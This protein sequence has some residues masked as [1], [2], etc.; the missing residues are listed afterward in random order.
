MSRE[1]HIYKLCCDGVDEF[2]IGSSFDIKAR[3]WKHK[4]V[5]NNVK[6]KEYN[7]KIYAFIRAKGG[8]SKWKFEILETALFENKTALR[9]REQHYK[10][11]LNPSLNM[12]N[13][14][15]SEEERRLYNL[16]LNKKY[17]QIKIDCPCGGRTD[18]AREAR[19]SKT[20]KHQKYLQNITINITNLNITI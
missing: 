5:C 3:K 2:Y 9:I 7:Y 4:S 1:G 6:R 20:N 15:L 18:K 8:F 14:Y 16:K 10:N 11:L 13:A 19:H 12:S 17:K